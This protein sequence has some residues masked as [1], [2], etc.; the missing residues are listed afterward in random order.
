MIA[1]HVCY[2]RPQQEARAAVELA[3]QDFHVFLPVLFTKPMFP[4]YIF[5]QFDRDTDP[6]GKIKSTRGC[7]D[8]LKDGFLPCIV[9]PEVIDAIKA[10]R[11]PVEGTP[12]TQTQLSVGDTVQIHSGPLAGLHG[13]FV[14]DKKARVSCLLEI[15]GK[16]V[17]VPRDSV[18][19]A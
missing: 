19:A 10:F 2:C 15:L 17:E 18:R 9:R 14:A 12:Q 11:E 8:L 4:R 5:V 13:L 3:N 16:R 7:I 6:W 1:W